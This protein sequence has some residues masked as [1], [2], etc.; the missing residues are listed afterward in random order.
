MMVQPATR[1]PATA[2]AT[3]PATVAPDFELTPAV[4]LWLN[5]LARAARTDPAVR[6][7]LHRLLQL[8]IARFLAPYRG[9]RSAI[10]GYDDIAQEAF[11][12]FAQLVADW[13]GQGSFA[14]YFF[15]FFPWRLRH[16]IAYYERRWPTSRL[17]VVPDD[18][19]L[20]EQELP[21][22]ATILPLTSLTPLPPTERQ[23]LSLRLATG[24]PVADLALPLG[25]SRR[26]LFRRWRQ[27]VNHIERE[28]DPCE[29]G[30]GINSYQ[31]SAG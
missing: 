18:D 17:T 20:F 28:L 26:T 5:D 13:S 27:L 12:V 2:A 15:G 29:R 21:D 19:D 30:T 16:A 3:P 22:V 14:A 4:H 11:L 23:L 24:L 8:K 7:E 10:G 31:R 25:C 1:R 9:W 6:N